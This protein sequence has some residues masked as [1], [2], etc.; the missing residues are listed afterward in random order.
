M[1]QMNDKSKLARAQRKKFLKTMMIVWIIS[2]LCGP[3]LFWNDISKFNRTGLTIYLVLH[4]TAF[5]GLF[6]FYLYQYK[7]V[8]K[9]DETS[10]G[11]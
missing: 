9:E 6:L 5:G 4:I 11:K 10:S 8:A 2:F 3:F 7:K 1:I